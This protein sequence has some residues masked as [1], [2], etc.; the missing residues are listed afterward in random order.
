MILYS[1]SSWAELI[2]RF[3]GTVWRTI[4]W[5]VALIAV[6]TLASY[7]FC[8]YTQMDL[9]HM[10]GNV[11]GSTVSFLLVFRANNAYGRYWQGRTLLT[12]YF[13]L[14]REII[15]FG[16]TFLMGGA[17]CKKWLWR[18]RDKPTEKELQAATDMNDD[19]VSELRTD[20]CRWGLVMA[21]SLQMHTRLLAEVEHGHMSSHTKYLVDWDRF[22][23]RQLTTHLEFVEI[24]KLIR[25]LALP[26]TLWDDTP[27]KDLRQ[28]SQ[29]YEQG[30][31]PDPSLPDEIEINTVPN[32]R[33]PVAVLYK[34]NEVLFRVMNDA[35]LLDKP[36]GMAERFI[37]IFGKLSLGLMH[38]YALINQIVATPLPF[39]YFHLCK[40][41][42][43]AYFLAFPFFITIE[44]GLWAN[45]GELICLAVALLGV[46]A[47]AT[48]LEDPFGDDEN[49]LDIYNKVSTL[50]YE[51]MF[52]LKICGDNKALENFI[53]R[54]LP[55]D[56]VV[57]CIVPVAKYLGLR[58]QVN[59]EGRSSD[60]FVGGQTEGL[61]PFASIAVSMAQ[62]KAGQAAKM[63]SIPK[64]QRPAPGDKKDDSSDESDDS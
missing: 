15:A 19:I 49:D 1:S 26:Q 50:E 14:L 29:P 41:L 6:Y 24:D 64:E 45:I 56:L 52:L 42:L 4:W 63:A 11:L 31:G 5:K 35:K 2:F 9:G 43:F 55:Q 22:R 61:D 27:L 23:I 53:W 58:A 17:R 36:Y 3:H 10:K 37:P 47:I 60:V 34:W 12:H 39:P 25:S 13:S 54:D 38:C 21:L 30:R 59:C 18:S 40:T 48:E 51:V 32:I 57:D 33:L 20:I 16:C 28:F 62:G 8:T 7:A 44:L 46:D